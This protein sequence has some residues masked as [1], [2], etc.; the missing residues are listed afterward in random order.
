[1]PQVDIELP[2]PARTKRYAAKKPFGF[3]ICSAALCFVN[4]GLP[5]VT[6]DTKPTKSLLNKARGK[7]TVMWQAQNGDRQGQPPANAGR[8]F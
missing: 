4:A 1:V 7:F 2:A 8:I 5:F 6:L 3:Y